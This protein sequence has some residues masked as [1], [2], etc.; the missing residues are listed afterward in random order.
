[1]DNFEDIQKARRTSNVDLVAYDPD[2]LKKYSLIEPNLI[3][4]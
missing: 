1:M 4:K 2:L 3:Y